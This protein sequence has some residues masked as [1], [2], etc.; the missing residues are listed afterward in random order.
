MLGSI[1]R[2]VRSRLLA[3]LFAVP[4]TCDA[5]L[6]D[7]IGKLR[8]L[9]CGIDLIRV[10][11][12]GDGGYLIPNDLQGIEYC[13]SPGV[14]ALSDFENQLADRGIK[15]FLADYSVESPA[16]DKPDFIFDKKF[17]GASDRGVYFTL[18]TWMDKYLNQYTGDLLL[19]MDIEG[20][21]YE[22]ILNAPSSLLNQFRIVVIEFHGLTR[23]FD[24]FTFRL[25]SATFEKLLDHFYVAHLHPNNVCGSMKFGE[26]EIPEMM[27]FTFLNKRR[28]NGGVPR[29]EF[30]HLLDADSA[31]EVK[32]LVLPECWYSPR[33]D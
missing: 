18:S 5:D 6:L 8:P 14:G 12:S 19:Q 24:P 20:A 29:R 10:G 31:P 28:V 30:P 9:D 26:I 27:E 15:S 11:S 4:R 21:E 23:L 17:L 16:V 25:F 32:P 22:V 2:R 13:F 33:Q 1:T 7:L 3:D